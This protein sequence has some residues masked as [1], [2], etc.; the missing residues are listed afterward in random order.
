M[1]AVEPRGIADDADIV[2]RVLGV[3]DGIG[4]QLRLAGAFARETS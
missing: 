3:Y 1:A 2:G 4:P